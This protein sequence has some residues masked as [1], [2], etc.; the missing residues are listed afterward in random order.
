MTKKKKLSYEFQ[1]G[2]HAR[3]E[4]QKCSSALPIHYKMNGDGNIFALEVDI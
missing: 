1:T 4:Y 3:I 2:T